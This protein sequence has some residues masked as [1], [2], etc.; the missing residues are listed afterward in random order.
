MTKEY[1]Y[2]NYTNG[3]KYEKT[4][5]YFAKPFDSDENYMKNLDARWYNSDLQYRMNIF[6]RPKI[7]KLCKRVV[8]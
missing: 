4:R 3:P 7:Q 2:F 8:S 6:L 5:A 1:L